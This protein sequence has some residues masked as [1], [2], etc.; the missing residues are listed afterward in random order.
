MD[1]GAWQVTVCGVAKSQTWLG[2]QHFQEFMWSDS[3]RTWYTLR[4]LKDI[5]LM[6]TVVISGWVCFRW[7]LLSA[8]FPLILKVI[9]HHITEAIRF[10]HISNLQ[11]PLESIEW[12]QNFSWV[13][14]LPGPQLVLLT[15]HMAFAFSSK[16]TS[17]PTFKADL[18]GLNQ[19]LSMSHLQ[20]AGSV[21]SKTGFCLVGPS[22]EAHL[23]W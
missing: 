8:F 22:W 23:S 17:P 3:L 11:L 1:R 6:F 14:L 21:F 15:S 4:C 16:I 19:R 2:D 20:L 13:F 10:P 12:S 9:M 5:L 18:E 7:F